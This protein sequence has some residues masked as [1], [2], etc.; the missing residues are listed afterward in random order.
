M[1]SRDR[2]GLLVSAL[3][4]LSGLKLTKLSVSFC[5][6]TIDWKL[7]AASSDTRSSYAKASNVFIFLVNNG[8]EIYLFLPSLAMN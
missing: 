4:R 6:K 8:K 2:D 5:K 3:L 7:M 1:E